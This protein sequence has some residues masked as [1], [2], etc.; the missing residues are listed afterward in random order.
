MRADFQDLLLRHKYRMHAAEVA[1][2][3]SAAFLY[4]AEISSESMSGLAVD[5]KSG[6]ITYPPGLSAAQRDMLRHVLVREPAPQTGQR[7][8]YLKQWYGRMLD[9]YRG[10]HTRVIFLRL[11]RGPVVRPAAPGRKT[12]AVRDLARANPNAVLLPESIRSTRSNA[13][14]TSWTHSTSTIAAACAFSQLAARRRRAFWARRGPADALQHPAVLPLP[15]R[16]AAPCS[17]P[18]PRVGASCCCWPPATSST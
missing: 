12:E 6:A 8:A 18:R 13:V 11:P 5:W 1:R 14:K 10:S 9:H 16:G 17:T 2:R 3:E 7:G 4:N 15:G